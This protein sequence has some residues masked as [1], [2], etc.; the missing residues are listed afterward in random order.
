MKASSS[1]AKSDFSVSFIFLIESKKKKIGCC[2]QAQQTL[3]CKEATD[4]PLQ[5]GQ[6][7][8]LKNACFKKCGD[9]IIYQDVYVMNNIP[10]GFTHYGVRKSKQLNN[11]L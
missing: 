11:N 7:C 9:E 8:V 1:G 4:C 5:L 6:R 10:T 3:A 2:L